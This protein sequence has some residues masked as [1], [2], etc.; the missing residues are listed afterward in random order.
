MEN[1][2]KSHAVNIIK[3]FIETI[4]KD[5]S[6]DSVY[7]YGSYCYGTPHTDSDIDIAVIL[8]EPVD[9]TKDFEIFRRAQKI[10]TDL[11]AVVFSVY[12]FNN[13]LSDIIVE[14]KQKG[15]KVA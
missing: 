8:D 6:V 2:S 3:E 9:E 5:Y 15:E 7:F 11:E 4:S 10:N 13:D 1:K 12:E 14:I